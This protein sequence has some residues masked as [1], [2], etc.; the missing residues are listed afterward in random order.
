MNIAVVGLGKLGLPIAVTLAERANVIGCDNNHNHLAALASG[1]FKT[2]EPGVD[3][4][5]LGRI[6]HYSA[7]I[8]A[9][10]AVSQFTFLIVPTPSDT[11]GRFADLHVLAACHE[12][13]RGL[14]ESPGHTVVIVSTVMPGS[15]AGPIRLAL[16]AAS[17]LKAGRNFGLVYSPQMVALGSVIEDFTHPDLIIIGKYGDSLVEPLIQVYD[18]VLKSLPQ[19]AVTTPINAELAKLSL[20][21][22]IS[23]KLSFVNQL[24][25]LVERIPGADVDAITDIIGAD[26]RIGRAYTKAGVMVGGPCFPRDLRAI[27]T[28]PGGYWF[29]LLDYHNSDSLAAI[30]QTLK[31]TK[32][33]VGILGM[34]YKVGTDVREGALGTMLSEMLRAAGRTVVE[35]SEGKA[36]DEVVAAS[37]VVVVTLPN[38]MYRGIA[39]ETWSSKERVVIDCWRILRH[40]NV[41]TNITYIPIGVGP[42]K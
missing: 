5:S 42:D 39:F 15:T 24:A 27:A 7:A 6:K 31:A 2:S 25:R 29:H 23:A 33:T 12:I 17:G 30:V 22:A 32:G 34:S 36:C 8:N 20:N 16:E 35:E 10:V 40:L 41:G 19:I 14:R 18:R 1:E 11:N 13:G 21:C 3:V 4:H 28:L 26:R 38:D 9:A 37:D